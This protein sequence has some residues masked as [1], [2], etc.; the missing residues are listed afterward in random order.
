MKTDGQGIDPGPGSENLFPATYH[1]KMVR[2]KKL[3]KEEAL[4]HVSYSRV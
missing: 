1:S 2:F 3:S 4:S